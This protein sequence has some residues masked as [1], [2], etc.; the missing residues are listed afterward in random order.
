MIRTGFMGC[1]GHSSRGPKDS[2]S[3]RTWLKDCTTSDSRTSIS[4]ENFD[5]GKKFDTIVAGDI[6]EHLSNVGA[7]LNCAKAPLSPEGRL[8]ITSP[9]PFSLFHIS[10]ALLKYPKTT[11]NVEHAHWICPQT[12]N[13]ECR[14]V[15]L[16]PF[17]SALIVDFP[18]PDAGCSFSCRVFLKSLG[19]FGGLLPE[20]LRCSSTL[21]IATHAE[22]Q[23]VQPY[24]TELVADEP[25][26]AA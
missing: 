17:H 3:G 10:Y 23:G 26:Y 7:F 16:K 18:P 1:C 21:F 25:Q 2:T 14:R 12:L 19:L 15:G 8:I 4:G 5:L 9:Y 13:E 6:V 22:G 11:W 20:T 24:R